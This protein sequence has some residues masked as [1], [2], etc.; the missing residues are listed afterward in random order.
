MSSV[1]QTMDIMRRM[2]GGKKLELHEVLT[3]LFFINAQANT[4]KPGGQHVGITPN[5]GVAWND[6]AARDRAICIALVMWG[7]GADVTV[8]GSWLDRR[9]CRAAG[10]VVTNDNKAARLTRSCLQG[11]GLT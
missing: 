10:F 2:Q 1:R 4:T 11:L 5:G 6:P 3:V 9:A 7:P 8:R